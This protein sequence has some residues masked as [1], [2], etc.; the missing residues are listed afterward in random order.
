MVFSGTKA[1]RKFGLRQGMVVRRI[2]DIMVSDYVCPQT[3]EKLVFT[4][5]V[6]GEK[7]REWGEGI[8]LIRGDVL[9]R[10]FKRRPLNLDVD[11]EENR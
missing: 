5:D 9:E 7:G 4:E 6:W 1:E 10:V 3:G 2:D 11:M 8:K